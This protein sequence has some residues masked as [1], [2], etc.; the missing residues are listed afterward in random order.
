MQ[1]TLSPF[2]VGFK[3]KIGAPKIFV[4]FF[5]LPLLQFR[6]FPALYSDTRDYPRRV[7]Q[8]I[9]RGYTGDDITP[10]FTGG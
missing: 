3:N 1:T 5:T 2:S 10:L 8:N 4:V 6:P 9:S 7:S